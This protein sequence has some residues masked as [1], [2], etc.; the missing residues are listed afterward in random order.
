MNIKTIQVTAGRTFNHPHEQYSNLR[1]SV[2]MVADLAD[3]ED[4]KEATK[5]L[6]QVAEGMV[7]DH[8][9]NLLKSLEELYQMTERTA[10]LQGLQRQLK[11]AQT[12]IDEIRRQNP[13]L[14]LLTDE[15]SQK[16]E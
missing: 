10:E 6:Q 5:Q 3:G 1:P 8:K 15:P 16:A 7:E 11:G 13:E 2:T 14:N 9:Q 4:A 12:R